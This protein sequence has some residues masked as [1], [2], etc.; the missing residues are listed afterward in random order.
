MND[1]QFL[2]LCGS[3][4]AA[5]AAL[6][7]H[8]LQ[9][10]REGLLASVFDSLD[11]VQHMFWKTRPDVIEDWYKRLD[12]L[13]GRVSAK[14]AARPGEPARLLVVSDH[15]FGDFDYKVHLNRWLIQQGYLR[16]TQDQPSGDLKDVSWS[17]SQ[18]YAIGLNSLSLN[19]V[20][21]EGQ[22]IVTPDERLAL[23][24][25][26]R[27]DLLNWKGPDGQPV[28]GQVWRGDEAFSGALSLYGP[29]LVMG[30]TPGFRASP[31]TGLGAW[32]P[33]ALEPNRDHWGADHC[34]DYQSVPGVLFYSGSL[35][36]YPAPS[37]RDIPALAIDSAP[38]AS[39]ISRP[40]SMS[41]EDQKVIEERLKSLGYL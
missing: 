24:E 14:L 30:Y 13:V 39:H 38:D 19:L 28:V 6:L 29:D 32:M 8:N 15:G 22:G 35:S 11:R 27:Q 41:A 7:F 9:N 16:P 5:R 31:E 18:A 12:A 26:L 17:G 3:I 23:S 10:F 2:E 34:F 25:R 40:P 33:E 37:Y 1:E 21:R 36:G 20:G 4:E